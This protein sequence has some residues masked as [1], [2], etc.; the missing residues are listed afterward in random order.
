[1]EIREIRGIWFELVTRQQENGEGF[2][3]IHRQTRAI[4]IRQDGRG[5]QRP[6]YVQRGIRPNA[7]NARTKR[8]V[9]RGFVQQ[10]ADSESTRIRAQNLQ[11]PIIADDYQQRES[12]RPICQTWIELRLR[13]TATS[14]TT[15]L[16][17]LTSLPWGFNS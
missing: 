11:V 10:H 17:T 13:S 7:C 3:L 14:N 4:F 15:P 12:R 16:I 8:I 6:G 9:L 2:R 1:M 5:V